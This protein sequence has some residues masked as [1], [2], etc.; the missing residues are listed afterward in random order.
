MAARREVKAWRLRQLAHLA[1]DADFDPATSWFILAWDAF[2][3]PVFP[4]DEGLRLARA[5]GADLDGD[6]VGKLC[7]KKADKLKIWDSGRRAAA[8]ALGP[9]DGS[10][11]MIDALHHAAWAGRQR[12]V[13]AAKE[14]VANAG[15]SAD[16]TFLSAMEALLEV[17]PPSRGFIGFDVAEGEARASADD[18]DALEKL[19][20]IAFAEHVDA[21]EQ[22]KLFAEDA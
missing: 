4:Y 5:V 6:I 16:P 12:S 13:E 9:A 8:G 2:K 11:A 15:L 21:P 7:E 1:K 20:R 10:R 19:R 14:L 17:L 3:A 22:L 18:F